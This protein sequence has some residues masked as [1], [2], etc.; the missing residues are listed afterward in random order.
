MFKQMRRKDRETS[1]EKAMEILS[2]AQY[3]FLSTIGENGYPYAI[4]VNHVIVD[5]RICFHCA[6][7]GAKTSNIAANS[8]VCFSVAN[9]PEVLAQ[10]LSTAYESAVA[11]G[12]ARQLEGEEKIKVLEAIFGK[13]APNYAGAS[14]YMKKH[15]AVTAI[16]EIEIDHLTGKARAKKADE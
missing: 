5:G 11:F 16:Y 13:F 15:G 10:A 9:S 1:A 3:G 6:A 8:K 7:S 2:N 12:T 4:A 14:D